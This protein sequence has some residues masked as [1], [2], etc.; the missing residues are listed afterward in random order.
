M[1]CWFTPIDGSRATTNTKPP[2]RHGIS[3]IAERCFC[4]SAVKLKLFSSLTVLSMCLAAQANIHSLTLVANPWM[5]MLIRI[6]HTKIL[7]NQSN[8]H[9]EQPDPVSCTRRLQGLRIEGWLNPPHSRFRT[10]PHGTDGQQFFLALSASLLRYVDRNRMT[11]VGCTIIISSWFQ[12][13]V[14]ADIWTY[15]LYRSQRR[16][17]CS[18]LSILSYILLSCWPTGRCRQDI[19]K[20]ICSLPKKSTFSM[21]KKKAS[22]FQP[23]MLT[24]MFIL[25]QF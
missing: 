18:T 5:M 12:P 7:T 9:W 21:S 22:A 10:C 6:I 8:G 20:W 19:S 1:K 24:E 3:H 4:A 16:F 25:S 13:V 15:F 14:D 23:V 11:H 2:F 17:L